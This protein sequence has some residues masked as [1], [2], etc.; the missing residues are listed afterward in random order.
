MCAR[1]VLGVK[2]RWSTFPQRKRVQCGKGRAQRFVSTAHVLA[3]SMH[4]GIADAWERRG[5]RQGTVHAVAGL[6]LC[7]RDLDAYE[8]PDSNARC[9]H[10]PLYGLINGKGLCRAARAHVAT[11]R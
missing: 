7:W 10:A 6:A 5:Y 8:R 3:S 2:H 11:T 1:C 9:A 4:M